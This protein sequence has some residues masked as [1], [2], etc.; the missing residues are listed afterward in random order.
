MARQSKLCKPVNERTNEAR[1]RAEQADFGPRARTHRGFQQGPSTYSIRKACRAATMDGGLMIDIENQAAAAGRSGKVGLSQ[2]GG[3]GLSA[4]NT[5]KTPARRALGDI[6]NSK[7]NAPVSASK[8]PAGGATPGLGRKV[9]QQAP[10]T[11][12]AASVFVDEVEVASKLSTIDDAPF[13][14]LLVESGVQ[15]LLRAP[16]AEVRGHLALLPDTMSFQPVAFEQEA[17]VRTDDEVLGL[18]L[19]DDDFCF[20]FNELSLDVLKDASD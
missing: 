15:A 14:D 19:E 4:R 8:I 12:Q 3:G 1:H 13:V 20:E 5:A 2:S 9:L 17:P 7:R 10:A 11:L 18:L 6:T 16:G